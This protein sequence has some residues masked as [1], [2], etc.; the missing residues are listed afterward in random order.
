MDRK[1]FLRLVAEDIRELFRGDY[2]DLTVVFP[3]KRASLFL[4]QELKRL[5]GDKPFWT[6][7]Y[8][9]ISD[10]F[11]QLSE[12]AVADPIYLVCQLHQV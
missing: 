6:P 10:I 1:G 2:S 3:N 11:E 4:N 7:Q 5:G 9:T 12:L 8:V